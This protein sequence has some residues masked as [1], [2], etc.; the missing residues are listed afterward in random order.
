MPV[1]EVWEDELTGARNES[2]QSCSV[3]TCSEFSALKTWEAAFIGPM[4]S[5]LWT[6]KLSQLVALERAVWWHLFAPY[7]FL[8]FVKWCKRRT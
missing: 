8:L 2:R 3:V 6:R 1:T 4:V 5:Q 7:L